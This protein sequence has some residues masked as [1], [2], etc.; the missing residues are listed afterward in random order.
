M[1]ADAV[2]S[3]GGDAPQAS[4]RAIATDAASGDAA[5]GVVVSPTL[6]RLLENITE[7]TRA[8]TFDTEDRM[9]TRGALMFH[10]SRARRV[11]ER[12]SQFDVSEPVL[13]PLE[14]RG[15]VRDDDGTHRFRLDTAESRRAAKKVK[16]VMRR[17]C[18]CAKG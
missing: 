7:N 10:R 12:W 17:G 9:P 11:W 8:S 4:A 5:G 13:S 16:Q 3:G 15:Y 1:H 18:Q 6:A 2:G 14:E